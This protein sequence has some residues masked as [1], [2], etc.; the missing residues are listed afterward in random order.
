MEWHYFNDQFEARETGLSGWRK[1][2]NVP[3]D[4]V[5][6]RKSTHK[7]G[8]ECHKLCREGFWPIPLELLSVEPKRDP[9]PFRYSTT[10][11]AES[12]WE[13]IDGRTF[14]VIRHFGRNTN[15][16]VVEME[17]SEYQ[18]YSWIPDC[19]RKFPRVVEWHGIQSM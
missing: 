16:C 7:A 12:W 15:T 8:P 14:K 9:G 18:P 17:L 10:E 4:S 1:T 3:R 13:Y 19:E 6:R 5:M 2:S 11:Y